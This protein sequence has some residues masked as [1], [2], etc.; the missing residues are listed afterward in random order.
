M[1]HIAYI[2]Q[3]SNSAGTDEGREWLL[4]GSQAEL[5]GTVA[6]ITVVLNQDAQFSGN[7][8]LLYAGLD[9]SQEGKSC[10]RIRRR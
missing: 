6:F 10:S 9:S 4:L 2:Q 8:I 7:L 5:F 3:Q 1:R